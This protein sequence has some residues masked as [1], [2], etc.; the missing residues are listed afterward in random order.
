MR[1]AP[2]A[3][4]LTGFEAL[5]KR[6][7]VGRNALLARNGE[8][9]DLD[10]LDEVDVDRNLLGLFKGSRSVRMRESGAKKVGTH[11]VR[12]EAGEDGLLGDELREL[13]VLLVLLVVVLLIV[14][15]L[16]VLVVRLELGVLHGDD[17]AGVALDLGAI[18]RA[19][20]AGIRIIVSGN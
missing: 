8:L 15:V 17:R 20:G 9:D 7:R 12:L 19:L 1:S 4:G 5:V 14:L 3:L 10:V 6:T 11:A 16:V 18:L 13:D 2:R